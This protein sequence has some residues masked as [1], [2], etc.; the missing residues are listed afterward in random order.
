MRQAKYAR[1]ALLIMSDGGDNHS[2]YHEREIKSAVREG[3]TL[4]YA[5]GVYDRYFSTIEEQ[6]GPLLL[7][8]I[9]EETGGRMFTVENPKDLVETATRIGLELRNQYVI[10]YRPM[11]G[12]ADGKWRKIRVKLSVPKGLPRCWIHAKQGYYAPAR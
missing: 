12:T 9:S 5:I 6:M 10:G 3:D 4:V 8:E 2:H 11:S 7:S 1:K